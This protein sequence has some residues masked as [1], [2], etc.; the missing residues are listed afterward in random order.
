MKEAMAYNELLTAARAQYGVERADDLAAVA[1]LMFSLRFE[2]LD[3]EPYRANLV[4]EF[5]DER[6][7][8]GAY[9]LIDPDVLRSRA[10]RE[11]TEH[12]AADLTEEF[13]PREYGEENAEWTTLAHEIETLERVV[14]L[15]ER[16]EDDPSAVCNFRVYGGGQWLRE[17]LWAATGVVP[18]D[19]GAPSEDSQL[20][21]EAFAHVGR[22]PFESLPVL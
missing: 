13:N 11:E 15:V 4:D 14:V 20:F 8:A 19:A 18:R 22:M 9:T 2:P 3:W 1:E 5:V 16:A 21:G 12:F 7:V 6:L 17:A 10:T